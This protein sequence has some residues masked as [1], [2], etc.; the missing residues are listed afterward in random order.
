MIYNYLNKTEDSG[1]I[2]ILIVICI[3]AIS[4]GLYSQQYCGTHAEHVQ[5]PDQAILSKYLKENNLKNSGLDSVAVTFHIVVSGGNSSEITTETLIGEI[6]FANR[7]YLQAGIKFFNCGS[8]RYIDGRETFNFAQGANLNR[9]NYVPNTINVYYVDEVTTNSGDPLCGYAQFPW[10]G[11]PSERYIVMSKLGGCLIKGTT[12]AHELGHFYGLFHTHESARGLEYV[13]GS[14]CMTAGDGLCDTPADPNLGNGSFVSGD[15]TYVGNVVDPLG[16]PYNPSVANIMSYA[17]SSCTDRLSPM[18]SA[19]VRFYHES[20]NNYIISACDF[21]PDFTVNTNTSLSIQRSD[22]PISITYEFSN[23]G[24]QEDYEVPI[25][26]YLSEIE[27]ERGMVIQKD[28]ILLNANEGLL[29]E[30]LDIDFPLNRGSQKYY[31]TILIDPEFKVLELNEQNNL[32]TLEIEIDNSSIDD[33]LLY[34]NPTEG[35]MRLFLRESG[36]T[37]DVD[38]Y[39]YDVRGVIMKQIEGF[40]NRDEYFTEI[41]VSELQSGLYFME[42]YFEN[43]TESRSFKF[44]KE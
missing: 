4:S 33:M 30:D 20:A 12:L 35:N 39:I 23:I 24:V 10:V 9:Q 7:Y 1:M 19:L 25:Y 27:G 11:N 32:Y 29:V 18:Q 44:V 5:Y 38:I 31:I 36:L 6:N 13:N 37:R 28:T 41:D 43:Q 40:K 22:E 3:L 34:P 17:P 8:P 21:F 16:Q 14:N 42:V 2:R 26:I 15:C